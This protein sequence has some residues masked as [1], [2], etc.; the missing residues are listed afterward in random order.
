MGREIRYFA[1]CCKWTDFIK[2]S[3]S[4][5]QTAFQEK[6][7][8]TIT[9]SVTHAPNSENMVTVWAVMHIQNETTFS[10]VQGHVVMHN[11]T[12]DICQSAIW[13]HTHTHTHTYL[14]I[15]ATSLINSRHHSLLICNGSKWKFI[16]AHGHMELLRHIPILKLYSTVADFFKWHPACPCSYN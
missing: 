10:Y 6:Q 12:Y 14:T 7:R 5:R 8:I 11:K 13:L 15:L 1:K 9:C 2:A 4:V 3:T 16:V